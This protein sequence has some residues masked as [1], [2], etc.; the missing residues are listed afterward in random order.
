[1][2]KNKFKSKFTLIF[3]GIMFGSFL[4]IFLSIKNELFYKVIN[5]IPTYVAY[6]VDKYLNGN[7][8]L[9]FLNNNILLY[10]E[11]DVENI[12]SALYIYV[13]TFS[14]Y[15]YN[16]I[17]IALSILTFRKIYNNYNCEIYKKANVSKILRIGVK[18]YV[19]KSIISDSLYYGM[20]FALPKMIYLIV[21][22]IFFPIG[23]SH[24]HYIFD[25]SFVSLPFLYSAYNLNAFI[26][27]LLDLIMAFFFGIIIYLISLII[28]SFIKNKPLSYFIFII[29]LAILSIIPLLF[30]GVPFIFYHSIYT[31]FNY[32]FLSNYDTINLFIPIYIIIIFCFVLFII[33]KIIYS[34]M[35]RN[36][37]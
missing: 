2:L 37:L 33:A 3:I 23:I 12:L 26:V 6:Y 1:M 25:A 7:I 21:L 32:A 24:N 29:V 34:N 10:V 31:Y 9:L 28:A 16:F 17:I 27:I 30:N 14:S 18:K 4:L 35:V 22:L 36:N 15:I 8:N 13:V 5:Y 20:L 11:N 19:N